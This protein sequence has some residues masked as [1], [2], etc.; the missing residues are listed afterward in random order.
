MV[1]QWRP[2]W[3]AQPPPRARLL[4]RADPSTRLIQ[5]VIALAGHWVS[6]ISIKRYRISSASEWRDMGSSVQSWRS[7]CV[8]R[9]TLESEANMPS[10]AMQALRTTTK[11]A[12]FHTQLAC[13][14]SYSSPAVQCLCNTT[15]RCP[16]V[17]L[18]ESEEILVCE[19]HLTL[20]YIQPSIN[21]PCIP[22]LYDLYL[23]LLVYTL[24]FSLKLVR[25]ILLLRSTIP[26]ADECHS[27]RVYAQATISSRSPFGR[28]RS[29]RRD[30]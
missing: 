8:L 16:M 3:A 24:G 22:R 12:M 9:L 11:Q 5:C 10:R 2:L 14:S 13:L 30:P 4:H 19:R 17:V 29:T 18:E 7:R 1:V 27:E 6:S 28:S 20:Y 15:L 23:V 21:L 26:T 25:D